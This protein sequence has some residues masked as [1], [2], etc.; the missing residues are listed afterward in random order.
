MRHY[1]VLLLGSFIL[2]LATACSRLA[3]PTLQPAP[4]EYCHQQRRCTSVEDAASVPTLGQVRISHMATPTLGVEVA[5]PIFYTRW[6]RVH[7]R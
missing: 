2:L 4:V 6:L 3:P 5:R 1:L 7:G